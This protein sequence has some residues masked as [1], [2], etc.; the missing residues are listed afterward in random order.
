MP[1][2]RF[3]LM[4]FADTIHI[5]NEL[6]DRSKWALNETFFNHLL[7]LCSDIQF[8]DGYITNTVRKYL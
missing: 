4:N 2:K 6:V 1:L 7:L 8:F 5:G 3:P